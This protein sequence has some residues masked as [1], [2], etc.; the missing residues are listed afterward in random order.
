MEILDIKWTWW[1]Y[2]T[3][4]FY[5]MW[6]YIENFPL[7]IKYFIQ[8]GKR[9]YADCDLWSLESYLSKWLPKALRTMAKIS[10]GYPATLKC[11]HGFD[12]FSLLSESD[13]INK[14]HSDELEKEW[15]R[16]LVRIAK[17]FEAKCQLEDFD[18]EWIEARKEEDKGNNEPMELYEQKK[19]ILNIIAERGFDL[20]KK[21]FD[22]LWD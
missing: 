14:E 4:P 3:A 1:D 19:K 7:K 22:S 6:G 10:H 2:I 15:K 16:I 13:I 17:G 18:M 11:K 8:R 5:R 12:S 21:H 20:F 9:G